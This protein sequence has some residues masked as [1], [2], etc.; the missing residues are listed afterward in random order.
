MVCPTD[1]RTLWFSPL[2]KR[3]ALPAACVA[4]L[5]GNP[6]TRR[7]IDTEIQQRGF[8]WK[9][10]TNADKRRF[11]ANGDTK[12]TGCGKWNSYFGRKYNTS[13]RDARWQGICKHC[14]RKRQLNLG[15]VIP[16]PPAYYDSRE[17][18]QNKAEELNRIEQVRYEASRQPP[19]GY[20]P[21]TT[22]WL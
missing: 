6:M 20:K 18:A 4:G 16:E 5:R 17:A 2:M 14:G 12:K 7:R 15:I 10:Q 3:I 21:N 9:C 11:I 22:R 8:V 1:C 19:R 13:K